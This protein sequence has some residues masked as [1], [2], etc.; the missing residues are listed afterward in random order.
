MAKNLSVMMID[1]C[2]VTEIRREITNFQIYT[3]L[4]YHCMVIPWKYFN[5]DDNLNVNIWHA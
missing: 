3:D 5:I 4:N 1:M 2:I